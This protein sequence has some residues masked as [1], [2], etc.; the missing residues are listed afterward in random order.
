MQ[1]KENTRQL[2]ERAGMQNTV[3]VL[4]IYFFEGALKT[5]MMIAG[6]ASYG[7]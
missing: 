3:A 2:R 1:K 7:N 6:V 5:M 4:F